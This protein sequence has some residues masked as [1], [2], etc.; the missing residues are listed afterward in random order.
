[1]VLYSLCVTYLALGLD[2]IRGFLLCRSILLAYR[3]FFSSGSRVYVVTR[4]EY[5]V[6]V[7]VI[8]LDIMDF[9]M[10]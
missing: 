3:G 2:V 8:S 7:D 4:L 6:M 10:I 1:M 5:I 9:S